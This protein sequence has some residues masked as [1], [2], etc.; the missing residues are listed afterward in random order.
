MK[1]RNNILLYII[2]VVVIVVIITIFIL[3]FS[4][5]SKIDKHVY[6]VSLG[7]IAFDDN[8]N[9]IKVEGTSQMKQRIDGNY[10]IYEEKEGKQY[11]YKIG[12]R[13]IIYNASDGNVKLYGNAYQVMSN[14]DVINVEGEVKISKVGATKFY[15]LADRKYLI[16]ANEIN[17]LNS[18]SEKTL[19]G[20]LFNLIIQ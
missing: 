11:K 20:A 4:F 7:S 8:F 17:S 16:V 18:F 15:K 19:K 14:G 10:Y 2:F 9:Y 1:K 13:A 5:F 12:E 3:F 6:E